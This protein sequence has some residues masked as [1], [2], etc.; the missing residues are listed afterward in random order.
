MQ[1]SY[2]FFVGDDVT[3]RLVSAVARLYITSALQEL[4][5]LLMM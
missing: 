2:S 3:T 4:H 5:W 1:R